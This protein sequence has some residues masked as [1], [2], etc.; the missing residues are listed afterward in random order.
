MK[1]STALISA[2][3]LFC[4]CA[5]DSMD[6][7]APAIVQPG[8]GTLQT[9]TSEANPELFPVKDSSKDYSLGY[10]ADALRNLVNKMDPNR[11]LG[12]GSVSITDEQMAEIKAFV[13]ENLK[14]DTPYDTYRKIFEW[15]TKNVEYAYSAPAY[16]DPYDVFVYKRCVCQGYANLLRAMCISQG[17]PCFNANGMLGQLGGHAWAYV[18]AGDT[19][20]V[21]DPTNNRDYEMRAISKYKDS[22]I[23]HSADI[24]L[25]EDENFAYNFQD[26]HFNV[27]EVKNCAHAYLTVPYSAEGIRLSS[28]HPNKPIPANVTQIYLGS[29]IK[30]LGDYTESLAK[31][32]PNLEEIFVDPTNKRLQSYKNVVYQ[33][34]NSTI[35]YYIPARVTRIE[36]KPMKVLEKNTLTYL[37][38]LEELVVPEGTETIEAYAVEAC[39]NLKRVYVPEALTDIDPDAFYRCGDHV[40]IV[41]V[42]TGIHE[43]T[44]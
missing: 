17:I 21:S 1:I 35:P 25:L 37:D 13:D 30:T 4:A 27:S 33:G 20:Y 24:T 10:T 31:T 28:F 32:M 8:N 44:K 26:Q 23:P 7:D 22:L 12:M 15:I 2:S 6:T 43:V 41:R 5:T 16:L 29:N 40:E 14:A 19:W 3:L 9:T 34:V 11:A 18:Y 38:N 42:P 39:P 36:L